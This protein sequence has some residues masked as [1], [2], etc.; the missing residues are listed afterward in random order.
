MFWPERVRSQSSSYRL[1]SKEEQQV[2]IKDTKC[3]KDNEK[4]SYHTWWFAL[5][6]LLV[7]M[8]V[9]M[10]AVAV[11]PIACL[12]QC[13]GKV[14]PENPLE[15][16]SPWVMQLLVTK[17]I[18]LSAH[19]WNLRCVRSVGIFAQLTMWWIFWSRWA[20]G[21]IC[22]IV[23]NSVSHDSINNPM[24]K[25]FRIGYVNLLDYCRVY[26]TLVMNDQ[27]WQHCLLNIIKKMKSINM[28]QRRI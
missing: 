25:D 21:N 27:S 11:L 17:N 26:K 7:V 20:L 28:W 24:E 18:S 2:V 19:H 23:L 10:I 5:V 3:K 16:D 9:I 12:R 14:L 13:G 4:K 6:T 8:A 1:Q 22:L 15:G